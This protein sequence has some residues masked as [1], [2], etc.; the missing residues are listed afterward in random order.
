LRSQFFLSST[1]NN[2]SS[3]SNA[4]SFYSTNCNS[5][6]K[7]NYSDTNDCYRLLYSKKHKWFS[8]CLSWNT[9]GWNYEKKRMVL[10]TLTR[11]LNVF[12]FISK[13]RE[14]VLIYSVITHSKLNFLII[15][16]F[17]KEQIHLFQSLEVWFFFIIDLFRLLLKIMIYIILYHY[18]H[19][20]Y[21]II[22]NALLV[23]F[24]FP[25]KNTIFNIN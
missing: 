3:S 5:Y 8:L 16:I 25:R 21:G 10:N 2:A 15:N 9:Y 14:M 20:I 22:L 7:Y 1:I 17:V 19:I 4:N 11:S 18:L 23:I 24:I 13:K 12:F 6:N